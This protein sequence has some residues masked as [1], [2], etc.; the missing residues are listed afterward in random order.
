MKLETT[1]PNIGD[2]LPPTDIAMVDVSVFKPQVQVIKKEEPKPTPKKETQVLEQVPDD[3]PDIFIDDTSEYLVSN[4]D[5][6]VVPDNVNV[7]DVPEDE[8]PVPFDVIEEVPIFP[9]CEAEV[10]NEAKRKCMSN[11]ISKHIRRHFNV[12]LA[13][14]LGLHV[15]Q[16]IR[17]QFKIDKMGRVAEIKVRGPQR[18]LE[19]EAERVINKL[20][21]VTP[22][23]QRD[24]NVGV[25][26]SLP[27]TFY[28]QN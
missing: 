11:K 28:V 23:R 15:K 13:D 5:D 18:E 20:P 25:I 1:I 26:Y 6:V 27:I 8:E 2:V 22:G 7:I 17:T 3:T 19:V 14:R 10:S 21:V 24:K 12:T 9:G 4:S 16:V